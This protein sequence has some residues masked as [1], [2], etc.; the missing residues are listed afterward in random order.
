MKC[1]KCGAE[2][3]S[4]CIY[5]SVC[6]Q[7]TQVG[8][9]YSVLED[10]YLRSLLQEETGVSLPKKDTKEKPKTA[11][12]KKSKKN[13]HMAAIVLCCVLVTT[14]AIGI[15]VKLTIDSRNANSYEYQMKMAAKESIAQNYE[16]ALNYYKTALALRPMDTAVRMSMAEI[17]MDKKEYNAAQVLYMEVLQIDQKNETACKNLIAMY[18]EKKDYDAILSLEESVKEDSLRP[19]FEEYHVTEPVISPIGGEYNDYMTVI[20]YSADE[21]PIYYTL[22][23][24]EPDE[25]NGILYPEEGIRLDQAGSYE[26]RAICRNKKGINSKVSSAEYDIVLKQPDYPRVMPDGG[27]MTEPSEIHMWA[28]R[29]C[30]IY[31]TWDA[32]NPTNLSEKYVGPIPVP[33]GNNV[34]SVYAV[35]NKTGLASRV[36]RTNFIYYPQ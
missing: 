1:A 5:C 14:A 12:K 21:D 3:K 30:T 13:S 10:D 11:K 31:Y 36:Y 24:T 16:R 22:D 32:S 28:E 2:L 18:E 15:A 27:T 29:D 6:G 8:S 9:D 26:L 7:E 34:L 23:G 4:G 17:Y 25:K 33:E 19:L 35:N 20:L